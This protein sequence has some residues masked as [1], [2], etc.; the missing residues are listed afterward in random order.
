[1]CLD[2]DLVIW[3][4]PYPGPGFI[5]WII[6]RDSHVLGVTDAVDPEKCRKNLFTTSHS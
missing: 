3:I 1:M 2:R 5:T 6:P 4:N